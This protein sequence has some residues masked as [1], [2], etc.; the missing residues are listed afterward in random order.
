MTVLQVTHTNTQAEDRALEPVQRGRRRLG[1]TIGVGNQTGNGMMLV[2]VWALM[3]HKKRRREITRCGRFKLTLRGE[4]KKKVNQRFKRVI[5]PPWSGSEPFSYETRR[6]KEMSYIRVSFSSFI[7]TP[8]SKLEEIRREEKREA[9]ACVWLLLD[10]FRFRPSSWRRP[11]ER[12][13]IYIL[14]TYAPT[15]VVVSWWCRWKGEILY[16][17]GQAIGERSRLM[18]NVFLHLNR[19]RKIKEKKKKKKTVASS[20]SRHFHL[21]FTVFF[22]FRSLEV[23]VSERLFPQPPKQLVASQYQHHH[24][25]GSNSTCCFIRPRS[26][27]DLTQLS[28]SHIYLLVISFLF[29]PSPPSSLLESLEEEGEESSKVKLPH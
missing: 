3:L 17:E 16:F 11:G 8:S 21:F 24:S 2:R 27:K 23:W 15:V 29:P 20:F 18:A 28:L 7:S 22:S 26:E 10:L 6:E 12:G 1:R 19:K 14:F 4:R 9:S 13:Y 5:F 25:W